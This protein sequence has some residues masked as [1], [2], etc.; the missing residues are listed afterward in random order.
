MKHCHFTEGLVLFALRDVLISTSNGNDALEDDV[1]VA[2]RLTLAK[3]LVPIGESLLTPERDDGLNILSGE[4]PE[5]GRAVKFVSIVHG[6]IFPHW[7][8][9]GAAG[10]AAPT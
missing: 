4:V 1:E 3:D 10:A 9:R 5:Y 8:G 2:A 6:S 7:P